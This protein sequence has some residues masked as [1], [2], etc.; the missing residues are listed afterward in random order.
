MELTT[1]IEAGFQRQFKTG[2]VFVDLTA[3]Y[4]TIWRDG[5]MLKFMN[6]VPCSKLCSLLDNMLII[7]YFQVFLGVKNSRWW[8]L[9]NGLPQ[10]SVLALIFFNLYISDIPLTTSNQFQTQVTMDLEILNRYFRHW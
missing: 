8:S 2:A 3:V 9:N 6:V 7:R 10:G 4:D 5:V 1:H